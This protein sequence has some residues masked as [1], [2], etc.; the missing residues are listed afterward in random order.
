MG[1]GTVVRARKAS[2]TLVFWP[3]RTVGKGKGSSQTFL[4]L[5]RLVSWM[6]I[7]IERDEIVISDNYKQAEFGA[8]LPNSLGCGAL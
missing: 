6:P 7:V 2:T 1:A 5:Y 8:E 3:H 4:S